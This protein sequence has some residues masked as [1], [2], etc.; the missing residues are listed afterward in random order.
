[1]PRNRELMRVFRD[2]EL[3]EQIG[4]GMSRILKLMTVQSL[5]FRQVLQLLRFFLRKLYFAE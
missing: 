1:M 4:S 3:A 5:N 2:I